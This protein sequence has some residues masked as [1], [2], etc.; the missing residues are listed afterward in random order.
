MS[1]VK[2]TVGVFILAK[3]EEVNIDR[4][5]A[6]FN[7]AGWPVHVLDSGSTDATPEIVSQYS[8]ATLIPYDYR[9]HCDA[10]NYIT[11]E[12][13]KKYRFVIILDSDMLISSSLQNEIK[14]LIDNY[15]GG[16][17]AVKA[18]IE[19]CVDGKPLMHGSLYPPKPFLFLTGQALFVSVGHAEKLRDGVPEKS[20]HALLR[21]DDRKGYDVYLQSQY[22]YSR[23]LIDRYV[24]GDVSSRDRIRVKWPFLIVAVPIYSIFV[25]RGLFSG[26]AGIVYALDRLIAEA[27][28]YRQ[29]VAYRMRKDCE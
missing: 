19:M 10:Y 16:W 18:E 9:T 23:S 17:L 11:T 22:R 21:H 14:D 27:I 20:A 1:D 15:D 8:F 29:A 4:S 2:N 25:K 3:N 12:L 26:R 24:Q 5:L 28:M 13:G 7:S 6:A